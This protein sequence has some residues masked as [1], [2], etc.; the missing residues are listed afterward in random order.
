MKK[1]IKKVVI[2]SLIFALLVSFSVPL[3][4]AA[5]EIDA[6]MNVRVNKGNIIQGEAIQILEEANSVTQ[7]QKV[8]AIE[9]GP[10]CLANTMI[11]G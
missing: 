6:L 11:H 4:F 5:S 1:T 3:C 9:D 7:V 8:E 2:G 10:K